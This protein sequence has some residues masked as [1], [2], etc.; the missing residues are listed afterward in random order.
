MPDLYTAPMIISLSNLLATDVTNPTV[1][2]SGLWL[3]TRTGASGT[4]A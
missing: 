1:G 2:A 4:L 3:G